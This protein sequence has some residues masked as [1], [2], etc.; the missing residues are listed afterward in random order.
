[1]ASAKNITPQ[2][3]SLEDRMDALLSTARKAIGARYHFSDITGTDIHAIDRRNDST[4]FIISLRENTIN[5]RNPL[6]SIDAD[7]L[8]LTYS[9]EGHKFKINRDY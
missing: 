5:V 9:Q 1:M 7:R 3:N 2:E 8:A 6:Y 4:A